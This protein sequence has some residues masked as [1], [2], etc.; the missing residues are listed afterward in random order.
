M[1]LS[2][3]RGARYV[4]ARVRERLQREVLVRHKLYVDERATVRHEYAAVVRRLEPFFR[5]RNYT[6]VRGLFVFGY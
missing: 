4:R 1:L 5:P 6:N 3:G 2:R